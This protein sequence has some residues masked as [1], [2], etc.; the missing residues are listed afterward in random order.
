MERLIDDRLVSLLCSTGYLPPRNEEEH[1]FFEQMYE[2]FEVDTKGWHV[3]VDAILNG[4]CS[5]NRA[6]EVLM[7]ADGC[8]PE[9]EY[10]NN[11]LSMAARNFENLPKDVIAKILSQH[12]KQDDNNE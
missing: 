9:I 3:D 11:N 6:E 5:L 4:F 1:L 7:V 8:D 10:S 12:K 2:D